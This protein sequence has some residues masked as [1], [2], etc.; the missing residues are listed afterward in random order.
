M[1]APSIVPKVSRRTF[2]FGSAALA[3][4]CM[5]GA[6]GFYRWGPLWVV[7]GVL[8]TA[9]PNVSL[10]NVDIAQLWQDVRDS[11]AIRGRR[12]MFIDASLAAFAGR[13]VLAAIPGAAEN[14][15]AFERIL[16]TQ[17]TLGSDF[18]DLDRERPMAPAYVGYD[19]ACGNRFARFRE[20]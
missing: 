3:A 1:K 10:G 6:F 5:G 9:L 20:A 8:Q 19:P 18:F 14:Y 11:G 13:D 12:R 2:L 15:A 16:V 17:L 4:V 7:Q